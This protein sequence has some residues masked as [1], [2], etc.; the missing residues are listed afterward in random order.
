MNARLGEVQANFLISL[1]LRCLHGVFPLVILVLTLASRKGDL[2]APGITRVDA[3]PD[4]EQLQRPL[5]GL[6]PT[7]HSGH[8][9]ALLRIVRNIARSANVDQIRIQA[10]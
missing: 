8:A 7:K 4:K 3:T 10:T 5:V 6:S 9:R 2:S 1:P